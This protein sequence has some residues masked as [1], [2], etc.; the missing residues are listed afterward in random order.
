MSIGDTLMFRVHAFTKARQ[1]ELAG[2]F[3]N[4]QWGELVM[5][6]TA[7]GWEL[8]YV[9]PPGNHEYKYIVDGKWT[10]DPENPYTIGNDRY[11]NSI[12]VVEPTHTFILKGFEDAKEV[13]VTGSFNG[14][15]ESGYRMAKGQEGW[16]FPIHLDPGK[17]TYKFLVDRK[18]MI[19]PG[20]PLYEPNEHGT[21]NSVVWIQ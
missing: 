8:P 9:L 11:T 2:S 14:W 7:D 19:D 15:N 16:I 18:W 3:N 6:K 20:N 13:I 21:D 5:D 17:Y 1:V 12:R 4:W 10:P